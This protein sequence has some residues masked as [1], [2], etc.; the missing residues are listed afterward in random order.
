MGRRDWG[1]G[2]IEQRS[3]RHWRVGFDLPRDPVTGKRRRI[4]FTIRGTKRE[5][6][7]ALSKAMHEYKYNGVVGDAITTAEYKHNGV[8]GDPITTVEWLEQWLDERVSDGKIGSRVEYN[9]RGIVKNHLTPE[10]GSVRLQDLSPTHIRNLKRKLLASPESGTARHRARH[11]KGGL[12]PRTVTKILRLVRQALQS[13]IEQDLIASNPASAVPMPSPGQQDKEKRA[14]EADEI[15]KLLKITKGTPYEMAVAFA[16]ATGARQGEILGTRWKALDLERGTVRVTHALKEAKDGTL[17]LGPP[18]TKR[19]RR[20]I[21]LSPLLVEMLRSHRA[22]QD[23]ARLKLGEAYEDHDLVF[24]LE[25][26]GYWHRSRFYT[27]YKKLVMRS[28]IERP[29]DGVTF[30]ALRHTAASQWTKANVDSLT[31]SRRL[32]HASAAF[33]LDNYAHELIGQQDDAARA[34][35]HLIAPESA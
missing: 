18:K 6:I 23:A 22:E 17:Y 33:T 8:D 2:S 15:K 32:G 5:A 34:L 31:I 29:E 19:S 25:G 1:T 30:H 14:L 24:P 11:P 21:A 20:T 7:E 3:K 27:G 26:G 4:R 35:D 13:A 16:L 10:I 12:Q 9:Y 28:G